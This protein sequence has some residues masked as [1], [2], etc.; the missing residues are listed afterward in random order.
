LGCPIGDA[1]RPGGCSARCSGDLELQ[2]GAALLVEGERGGGQRQGGAG[3][4]LVDGEGLRI[5]GGAG[6]EVVPV[7]GTDGEEMV[8][9]GLQEG[10]RWQSATVAP[11][12]IGISQTAA[13]YTPRPPVASTFAGVSSGF[14]PL[15]GFVLPRLPEGAETALIRH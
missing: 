2:Y 11:P 10:I 4:L 3:R 9:A 13:R 6:G 7:S 5:G 14:L 1:D 8:S 15:L 12:G